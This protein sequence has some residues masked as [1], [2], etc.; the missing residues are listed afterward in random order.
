MTTLQQQKDAID[1][2]ARLKKVE[3]DEIAEKERQDAADEE[4]RKIREQAEY[5][6][7]Q[8]QKDAQ[9]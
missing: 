6:I 9:V 4:S 1:E 8:I 7:K 5:D 3:A 2:E